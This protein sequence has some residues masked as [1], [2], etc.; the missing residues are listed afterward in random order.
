MQIAYYYGQRLRKYISRGLI[1]QATELLVRGCNVNTA[2]GEGMT[3]LHYAANYNKPKAI[4][5]L[6]KFY[7]LQFN[8]EINNDFHKSPK[9][10]MMHVVY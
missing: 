8:I 1:E 10:T 3:S 4:E 5:A 9:K 2:D 6:I 7:G